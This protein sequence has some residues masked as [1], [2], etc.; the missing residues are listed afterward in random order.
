M[1]VM[2]EIVLL[3]CNNS[4]YFMLSPTDVTTKFICSIRLTSH[5]PAKVFENGLF[6]IQERIGLTFIC[7]GLLSQ[8]M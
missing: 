4:C 6:Y 1:H 5:D 3:I 8:I 2:K 7:C